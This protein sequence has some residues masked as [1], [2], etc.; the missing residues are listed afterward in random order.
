[1]V[2][3]KDEITAFRCMISGRLAVVYLASL[4]TREQFIT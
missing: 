2:R 1:M 3:L 4:S